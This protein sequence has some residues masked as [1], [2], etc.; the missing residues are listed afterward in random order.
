MGVIIME[1]QSS[2]Q[3]MFFKNYSGFLLRLKNHLSISTSK[4]SQLILQRN[5]KILTQENFPK[6][7]V[8]GSRESNE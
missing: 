2:G 3:D 7:W 1:F 5:N 4:L 6:P 8:S